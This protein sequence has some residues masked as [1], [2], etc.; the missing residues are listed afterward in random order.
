MFTVEMDK[1]ITKTKKVLLG[2]QLFLVVDLTKPFTMDQEVFPGD[3]KPVR[4]I[5]SSIR[6]TGWE[7]YIHEVADHHF[8]PHADAPKH[9]DPQSQ[10]KGI[11]FFG[12]DYVFNPAV[13]IDLSNNKEA[14]NR[15]GI[16]YLLKIEKR[17]L[18]PYQ[19][20]LKKKGAVIIRTG[21]DKWL[22]A[23]LPNREELIPFFTPEAA[24]FLASFHNIKVIG[25][26][27]LNVDPPE[28]N[29]AHLSFKEKMIV[30]GLVNLHAIPAKSREN[31]DIQTAPLKITGATGS[32]VTAFAFVKL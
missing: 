1:K 25:T 14:G 11:E 21:F 30:E 19:S 26:D 9:Y 20:L 18:E 12:L 22:E 5:L 32:P 4:R 16:K 17:F 2:D 10:D 23:N 27:S 8:Q 6:E 29:R 7:H 24:G 13:L 31:F 15:N 28:S 3:P